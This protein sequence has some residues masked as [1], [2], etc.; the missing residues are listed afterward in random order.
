M[1]LE[2][3]WAKLSSPLFLPPTGPCPD[4]GEAYLLGERRGKRGTIFFSLLKAELVLFHRHHNDRK[5]VVIA[6]APCELHS[7]DKSLVF[8]ESAANMKHVSGSDAVGKAE[9]D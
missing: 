3:Q 1:V 4:T 5:L 7:S 2:D 9:H 8:R 6:K